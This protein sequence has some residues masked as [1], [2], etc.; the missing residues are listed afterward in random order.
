MCIT[1]L[2]LYP[3][4]WSTSVYDITWFADG[5]AE[6]KG[7]S[8]PQLPSL[9]TS[10][11]TRL[12]IVSRRHS[13]SSLPQYVENQPPVNLGPQKPLPSPASSNAWWGR[14]LPGQPGRDHPFRFRRAP[15][16]EYRW[17]VDDEG[18]GAGD[19]TRRKDP[20]SQVQSLGESQIPPDPSESLNE[21]EP[22]PLGDRSQWVRAGQVSRPRIA[23]S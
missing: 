7:S 22:I 9:D 13:T 14:L 11:S 23:R 5:G 21:D 20:E 19:D 4:L 16:P 6:D 15:G 17:W 12:S 3:T 2:R 10:G 18:Q 8:A 1:H